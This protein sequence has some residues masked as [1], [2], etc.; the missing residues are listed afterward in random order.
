M[1]NL[2]LGLTEHVAQFAVV[3]RPRVVGCEDERI[4]ALLV[5]KKG[6]DD[7]DASASTR[8]QARDDREIYKSGSSGSSGRRSARRARGPELGLSSL[9]VVVPP[10]TPLSRLIK[11]FVEPWPIAFF[12]ALASFT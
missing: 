5:D 1:L 11:S 4:D 2:R 8:E 9:P 3:A 12:L 6:D 7:A 10:P